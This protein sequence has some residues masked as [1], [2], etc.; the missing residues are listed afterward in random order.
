MTTDGLTKSS[1]IETLL[2]IKKSAAVLGV[3][4]ASL[5]P[6]MASGRLRAVKIGS[7]TMI[8]R[9]ELERFIAS[10]PE[11]KFGDAAQEAAA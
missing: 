5:Y 11:A 3:C 9:S 2:P 8:P 7:R 4:R 10:L 6:L 1:P